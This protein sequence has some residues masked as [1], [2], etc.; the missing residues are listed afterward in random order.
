MKLC[1]QWPVGFV[2][3]THRAV[4][5][6]DRSNGWTNLVGSRQNGICRKSGLFDQRVEI[7]GKNAIDVSVGNEASENLV[8]EAG[9]AVGN[10]VINI[11][12]TVSRLRVDCLE[13]DCIFGWVAIWRQD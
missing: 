3:A 12:P 9:R 10:R 5:R 6:V 7:C 2:Q 11:L 8:P 1:D 13:S 4:G